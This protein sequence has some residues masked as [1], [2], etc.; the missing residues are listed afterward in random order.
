MKNFF[1]WQNIYK[2]KIKLFMQLGVLMLFKKVL[3][4]LFIFILFCVTAQDTYMYNVVEDF[5]VSIN[6]VD[7]ANA[8]KEA[9]KKATKTGRPIFIPNGTYNVS[10]VLLE[11]NIH[12]VGESNN[13]CII[14]AINCNDGNGDFSNGGV[15][16][17]YERYTQQLEDISFK[18]IRFEGNRNELIDTGREHSIIH[19]DFKNTG[20]IRNLTVDNCVFSNCKFRALH[21]KQHEVPEDQYWSKNLRVLNSK[22]YGNS[23]DDGTIPA[24]S[25]VRIEFRDTISYGNYFFSDIMIQNCYAEYI[26]TLAD[27]KR[28]C[29]G[30]VVTKC[31]T[32]NMHDC[33]HSVDGSKD[34]VISA[35]NGTMINGT[36]SKWKKNFLEVQGENIVI[37]G[38]SFNADNYSQKGIHITDYCFPNDTMDSKELGNC[39][40][41]ILISDCVLKNIGYVEVLENG[42]DI[43]HG[44]GIKTTNAHNLSITNCLIENSLAQPISIES[45]SSDRYDKDLNLLKSRNVTLN[46]NKYINCNSGITL[47]GNDNFLVTNE[48]VT[49]FRDADLK[50]THRKGVSFTSKW[51]ELNTNPHLLLNDEG[52]MIK[53]F[54]T[55]DLVLEYDTKDKPEVVYSSIDEKDGKN[56]EVLG[57]VIIQDNLTSSLAQV[58]YNKKIECS[59]DEVLHVRIY[60]KKVDHNNMFS[61]VFAEYHGDIFRHVKYMYTTDLEDKWKEFYCNYVPSSSDIDNVRIKL[62]PA[63]IGNNPEALGKVKIAKL[64]ISKTPIG[65]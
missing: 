8:F 14:K 36:Y 5:G 2:A 55:G 38:L 44:I 58:E 60:G 59:K 20:Y 56:V 34:G 46:G 45:G 42:T 1:E 3:C 30:F 33:H 11:S 47:Q 57:S 50:L 10:S 22:F 4:F 49:Y 23:I 62:C 24:G 9:F 40:K 32:K 27:L 18:N 28:G 52:N 51:K 63:T 25:A 54:E 48:N 7:N 21:I 37:S 31:I 13:L 16:N 39:S 35:C 65:E 53:D 64:N 15:F 6:N 12:L 26:R 17:N 43:H 61:I 19:L 41:N 29:T